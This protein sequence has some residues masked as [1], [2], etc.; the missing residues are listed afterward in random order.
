[1]ADGQGIHKMISEERIKKKMRES[2]ELRDAIAA[3][4]SNTKKKNRKL[5]L[6][7]IAEKI[8][9]AKKHLS[10]AE[11]AY[12][13]ILSKE[14]IREFARVNLLIPQVKKMILDGKIRHVDVAD[15]LSRLPSTEQLYIAKELAKG[16]LN[17]EDLRAVVSL[18]KNM[19]NTSIIKILERIKKSRNIKQ[20]IAEFAIPLTQSN[21]KDII[22]KNFTKIFGKQHIQS[23][24]LQKGMGF[25]ILDKK[26]RDTL[27]K[28][29][30]D[31]HVTKNKF[32]EMIISGKAK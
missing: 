1:M 16:N 10:I 22:Q 14:M 6:V 13:I 17:S 24:S 18:R 19:P 7:A 3:L 30:R 12:V 31:F 27:V 11:I 32:I 8:S 5:N 25:V 21:N 20:Y 26:G 9:V 23:I 15:R 2:H 4:I 29:T 28:K